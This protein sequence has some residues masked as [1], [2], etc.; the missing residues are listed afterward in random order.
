MSNVSR[1]FNPLVG[2]IAEL[3]WIVILIGLLWTVGRFVIAAAM[4]EDN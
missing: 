4:E 3:V 1:G 2:L